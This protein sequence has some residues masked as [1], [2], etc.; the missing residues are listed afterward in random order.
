MDSVSLEETV[1]SYL[2]GELDVEAAAATIF[3]LQK[4]GGGFSLSPTDI[5][6]L[7]RSE[8]LLSRLLWLTLRELDPQA[9]ADSPFGAAEFRQFQRRTADET[10]IGEEP[11]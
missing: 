6:S 10:N 1:A 3:R 8:A 5:E 9:T 7:E 4:S 11:E 2:R